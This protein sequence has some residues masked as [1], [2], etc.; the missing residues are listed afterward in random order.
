MTFAVLMVAAVGLGTAVL[1]PVR[2]PY[3]FE[4]TLFALLCGLILCAIWV[5]GA[6]SASLSLAF[7]GVAALAALSLAYHLV[8]RMRGQRLLF[9][10]PDPP[11]R[12]ASLLQHARD[13]DALERISVVA[14]SGGLL[15]AFISALAP[16]TNWDAGAAHLA[17]PAAYARLGRIDVLEANNYSA[18]PHMAHALFALSYGSGSEWS[19][20]LVSWVFAALGVGFAYCLGVRLANRKAGLIGAAALATAPVFADQAGTPS[21]DLV[22]A[23]I[24]LAAIVALVV[25]RQEEQSAWLLVA[26]FLAGSACGVRHTGYL[27]AALLSVGVVMIAPRR[28]QYWTALFA[29]VIVAGAAPWL[30]RSWLTVGNPF[31][32]F[33]ASVFGSWGAFDADVASLASHDSMRAWGVWDFLRFPWSVVMAP[34]AFDGWSSNPG[35]LVLLLGVPGIMFGG[36][37]AVLIGLFCLAGISAMFFFRQHVRYLLPFFLPMMALA[38]VG[39][40]RIPVARR[41]VAGIVVGAFA[42]GLAVQVAAIHYKVPVVLGMESRDAYLGDRIERYSAFRWVRE[43]LPEDAVVLS[44]DPR[45][46]YFDRDCYQ[47]FEGLKALIGVDA[48]TEIAWFD[49][50]AIDYVF[51]PENYVLQSPGFR[52]TGV[53]AVVDGWR[54]DQSRFV[55]IASLE[56][57]CAR[58]P[59]TELVEIYRVRER[60]GAL[61]RRVED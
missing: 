19:T 21:I 61:A 31:F 42:L 13:L 59:G 36:R 52:E 24:V 43:N 54:L 29:F 39:V 56:M 28:K 60:D 53:Q 6:G 14:I 4:H 12:S 35:V 17:L 32:P 33:F 25:W 8:H 55:L 45:A 10:L 16:V 3:R 18:Y 5:I 23:C 47:N 41:A 20:G 46:Y 1:R 48:D 50:H 26:G 37:R 57:A 44:L 15:M 9:D 11:S 38:G 7:S 51:Y 2:G 30:M 27:T 58:G 40:V 34:D 22:F 49:Q